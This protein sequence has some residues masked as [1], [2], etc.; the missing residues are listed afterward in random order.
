MRPRQG[1]CSPTC[2][3]CKGKENPTQKAF[4]ILGAM[5]LGVTPEE[6]GTV[7]LVTTVST[8]MHWSDELEIQV[9]GIWSNRTEKNLRSS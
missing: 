7:V 3:Y 5:R 9:A 1:R 2:T 8:K 4:D 6:S